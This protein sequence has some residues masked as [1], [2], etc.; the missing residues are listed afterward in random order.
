M[1]VQP[2]GLHL[3]NHW[4]EADSVNSRQESMNIKKLKKP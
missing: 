4:R 3:E 2:T 1:R